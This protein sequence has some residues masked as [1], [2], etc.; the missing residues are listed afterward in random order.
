[1]LVSTVRRFART[2]LRLK[3]RQR[4]SA[5]AALMSDIGQLKP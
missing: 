3:K 4:L 2:V 1:M 5:L